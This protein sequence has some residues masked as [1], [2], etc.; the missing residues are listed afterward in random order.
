MAKF[1]FRFEP[2]LKQRKREEQERQRELATR[3]LV[4]VNLQHDLKRLDESLKSAAEDL[5]TNHLTGAIDL[6]YLAAHR[7]FLGAMR[8]QGLAIV[9]QIAAAQVH[10]DEARRKLAEAAKQRKVMERLRE[11][12]FARWREDQARR[13]QAE[14]D[15][16][17]SQIGYANVTEDL[18][19]GDA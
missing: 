10:V 7:R 14:M 2:V 6:N 15:E 16:I 5:R 9:Q 3:E 4:A 8:R 1:V 12:Q 19:L 18:S 11:K 13:E 17:G